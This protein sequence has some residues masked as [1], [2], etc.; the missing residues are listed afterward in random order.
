[1]HAQDLGG[2]VHLIPVPVMGLPIVFTL[3]YAIESDAGVTLVDAG[4]DH[5]DSWDALKEGLA[6]AGYSITDVSGVVVTHFHPDHSGLADRVRA[7][8]GAWTALHE[9]EIPL[10]DVIRELGHREHLDWELA[11]LRRIGADGEF[12]RA[13]EES[14]GTG[15]YLPT[16][17]PPDRV[18]TDGA[19][20]DLGDRTL[21]VIWTPGHSPGHI[22]LHL[23]DEDRLFTGDH[24]LPG[25]TPHIGMYPYDQPDVDPLGDFIGSLRRVEELAPAVAHPAHED[26]RVELPDRTSGIRGHHERRLAELTEVLSAGPLTLWEATGELTWNEPWSRMNPIA[27]QMA[28]GEAAAHLRHLQS[29]RV[30][31]G[32][33]SEGPTLFEVAR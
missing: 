23:R 10:I 20:L 14:G 6:T 17:L 11:N 8:S 25:T 18:L 3:V 4:W 30:V 21:R 22:C 19:D 24:V 7:E 16:P 26:P 33:P 12:L 1:M 13:Y 5:P 32:V 28:V 9:A 15:A 29:R 31:R 27:R 2:G